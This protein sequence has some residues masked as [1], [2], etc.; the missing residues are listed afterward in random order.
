MLAFL[1]NCI[2]KSVFWIEEP[3]QVWKDFLP[4]VGCF[5]IFIMRSFKEQAFLIWSPFMISF[6]LQLGVLC[7]RTSL[8][9]HKQ[10]YFLLCFLPEFY[11]F[12]FYLQV[13]DLKWVS[14]CVWG[15]VKIKVHFLYRWISN[16]SSTI[17]WNNYS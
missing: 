6:P 3:C 16:C 7:P 15:K 8:P 10:K 9:M 17:C 5:F 12:S 4:F 14:F 2:L 1:L 13:Y 11:Y